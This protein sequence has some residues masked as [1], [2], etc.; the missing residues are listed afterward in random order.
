MRIESNEPHSYADYDISFRQKLRREWR[1]V[2]PY[3]RGRP[4]YDTTEWLIAEKVPV[5][6]MIGIA[7][8]LV[9]IITLLLKLIIPAKW[10]VV[11]WIVGA[12]NFVGKWAF[13]ICLAV[14][15]IIYVANF[16][17]RIVKRYRKK[18]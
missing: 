16:I 1:N 10:A 4:D 7:A 17:V 15:I 9:W 12:L 5:L 11:A 3:Y 6:I 8:V 13:L 18:D 14:V 2:N